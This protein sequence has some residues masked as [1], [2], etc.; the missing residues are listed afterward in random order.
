VLPAGIEIAVKAV[1]QARKKVR[2][3][4]PAEGRAPAAPAMPLP[5]AEQKD[6]AH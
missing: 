3:K 6:F 4:Y 2:E 1:E 5:P